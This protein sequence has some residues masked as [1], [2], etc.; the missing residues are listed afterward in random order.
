MRSRVDRRN[1][2][3]WVQAGGIGDTVVALAHGLLEFHGPPAAPRFCD[4]FVEPE[5]AKTVSAQESSEIMERV[6]SVVSLA[7]VDL[8]ENGLDTVAKYP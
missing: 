8:S 1:I 5:K 7:E 2:L 6:L 4:D 3:V